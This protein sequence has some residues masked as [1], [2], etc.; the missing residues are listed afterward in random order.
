MHAFLAQQT[1]HNHYL[2]KYSAT[3]DV[4]WAEA[5]EKFQAQDSHPD[6]DPSSKELDPS[7]GQN[8]GRQ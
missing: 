1:L 6:L 8:P 3:L 2:Q 7:Y 5:A 4:R